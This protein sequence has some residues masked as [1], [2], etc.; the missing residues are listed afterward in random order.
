LFS[1][2][3]KILITGAD[4]F[5][6]RNLC[7]YLIQK[8][9]NIITVSRNK[10]K[11]NNACN[12]ITVSSKPAKNVWLE[13]LNGCKTIIHLSGI[14]HRSNKININKIKEITDVNVI[15]TINLAK[16]AIKNNVNRFIFLSSISVS[17]EKEKITLKEGDYPIGYYANSKY[18]AEKQLIKL[19]NNSKLELV[20]IRPPLVYG[21]NAPGNYKKISKLINYYI[22]MPFKKINNI[23]N[24][25]SIYNL[26]DFIYN[27]IIYDKF[28]V[29]K[30]LVSDNEDISTTDFIKLIGI[31]LGKKPILFHVNHLVIRLIAK[32]FRKEKLLEKLICN[33]KID[34]SEAKDI[35]GWS[36]PYSILESFNKMRKSRKIKY[37]I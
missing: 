27:C 31:N 35:L 26:I 6:G 4:G 34:T 11:F 28:K 37:D 21:N 15:D 5:I 10:K 14:A 2:K 30:F 22:P 19:A 17:G 18:E 12:H 23:K 8:K 24:F 3:S 9:I 36:P 33:L 16:A 1:S 7:E 32:L 20:I 25:I 29:Q 13:D